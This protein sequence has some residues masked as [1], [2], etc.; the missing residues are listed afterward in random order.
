MRAAELS[1]AAMLGDKED[2]HLFRVQL[3]GY[4]GYVTDLKILVLVSVLSKRQ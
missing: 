2:L 1:L 4:M 3:L